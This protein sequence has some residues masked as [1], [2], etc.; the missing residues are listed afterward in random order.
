MSFTPHRSSFARR[1]VVLGAILIATLPVRALVAQVSLAPA[2]IQPASVERLGLRVANPDPSP[3]VRVR[4][5]VPA[6]FTVLGVDAPPGWTWRLTPATDTAA[7]VIEWSGDSLAVGAFREFALLARLGADARQLT[8]V[9]PVEVSH[10]DGRTVAWNR[11]GDAPPLTMDISGSTTVS[12]S[13]AVALAGGA[14]GIAALALV[15]ALH[16]RKS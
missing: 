12:A 11:A 15:M 10:A 14:L 7:T 9:F 5:D 16:R 4:L 8:L 2:S 13:G 1:A 6:V 3:V